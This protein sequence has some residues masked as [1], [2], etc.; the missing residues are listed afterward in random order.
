MADSKPED[1]VVEAE[2]AVNESTEQPEAAAEDEP[3]AGETEDRRLKPEEENWIFYMYAGIPWH[4][5]KK[6][7]DEEE[8]KFLLARCWEMKMAREADQER[9]EKRERQMEENLLG[10]QSELKEK[11]DNI[12][13]KG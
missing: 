2:E 7:H 6:I 9:S 1:V 10:V 12:P 13:N 3:K 8:R 5:S 4:E 11:M